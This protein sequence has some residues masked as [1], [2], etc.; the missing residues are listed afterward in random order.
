MERT[1]TYQYGLVEIVVHRPILDEKERKKR[2]ET[3]RRAVE[4][5]GKRTIKMKEAKQ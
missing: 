4:A 1:N 5:Y 2:E 3:L